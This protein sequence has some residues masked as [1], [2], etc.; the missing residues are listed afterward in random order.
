MNSYVKD[1][2]AEV[3]A[4]NPSEPEFHQAVLE[5]AESLALVLERHP[6]YRSAKVLERIIEPE[7]V[8]M[9]RVP[10]TDDQGNVQI[11]RGFRIEMNSAIGPYKGG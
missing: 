5:V 9:F 2:M 7:R 6:E 1:L 3:K 11:N 10:W 4:K 8:M